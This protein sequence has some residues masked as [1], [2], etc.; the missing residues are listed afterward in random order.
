MAPKKVNLQ[1]ITND[2]SRRAT[3]RKRCK[4]LMK[5]SGA[6]VTLCG[7]RVCVVVYG[8]GDAQAQPVVW[9]SVPEATA[10]L[11]R[12]KAMPVLE[13]WKKKVN[14]EEFLRKRIA[15]L[16]L[17]VSKSANESQEIETASLL[18]EA[19]IGRRPGLV[20]V[21]VEDLES[22]DR[23]V[24]EKKRR[25]EE[26]LRELARRHGAFP[27]L[28]PP[29]HQQPPPASSSSL[30]PQVP[31][32]LTQLGQ[33]LVGGQGALPEPDPPLHQQLQP[34]SPLILPLMPYTYTEMH[35]QVPVEEHCPHQQEQ[36]WLVGGNSSVAGPSGVGDDMMQP[37]DV[38]GSSRL[39]WAW[40]PFSP[41]E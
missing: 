6:L 37:F 10:L 13:S 32:T 12:F 20:G 28:Q 16:V 23:M 27:V 31:Y 8:E 4:N 1:W 30:Q 29:L 34:A 39:P 19:T 26:R 35:E 18:H 24:E 38:G 3:F 17:Q 5:K 33:P 15:K 14:Q 2:L 41:M 22:L 21:G 36:D 40:D 7:V 11:T 25:A 9:P